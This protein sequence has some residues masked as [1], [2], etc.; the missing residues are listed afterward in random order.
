MRQTGRH[1]HAHIGRTRRTAQ[2]WTGERAGE[3]AHLMLDGGLV[4]HSAW[5]TMDSVRHAE[6][7]R[8]GLGVHD[9]HKLHERHGTGQLSSERQ[10]LVG[11]R[12][13]GVLIASGPHAVPSCA[14]LN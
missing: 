10:G 12:R 6:Q 11:G 13:K 4:Q 8:G 14:A 7:E 9:R 1:V 5:R 3:G 2:A